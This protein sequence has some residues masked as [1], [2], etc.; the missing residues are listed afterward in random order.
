MAKV[1]LALCEKHFQRAV[2][3]REAARAEE[4]AAEK[5]AIVV[6]AVDDVVVL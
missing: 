1:N 3:E 2:K 6:D 4:R 5:A